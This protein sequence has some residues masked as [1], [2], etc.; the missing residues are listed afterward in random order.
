L[1]LIGAIAYNN[2][3]IFSSMYKGDEHVFASASYVNT[4]AEPMDKQSF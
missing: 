2:T 1:I 3:D 4:V